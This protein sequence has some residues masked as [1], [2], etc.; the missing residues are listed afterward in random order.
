MNIKF[1]EN[2]KKIL[3]KVLDHI[4][5]VTYQNDNGDGYEV[6]SQ[7]VLIFFTNEEKAAFN[8]ALKKLR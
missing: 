6:E 1:N 2:Q 7:D 8:E 5:N 4:N 3:F